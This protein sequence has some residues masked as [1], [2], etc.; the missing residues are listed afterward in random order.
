MRSNKLLYGVCVNN[1]D[2]CHNGKIPH[3]WYVIWSSV[4]MRVYSTKYHKKKPTYADYILHEDWKYSAN[5]K[6]WFDEQS[7]REGHHLDKDLLVHGNKI[8]GP[9]TCVFVPPALNNLF[10]DC[11][12][13]RRDTPLGVGHRGDGKRFVARVRLDSR[14]VHLGHYGTPEEAQRAYNRAKHAHCLDKAKGYLESGEIDQRIHDAVV[15]KAGILF[16]DQQNED[17]RIL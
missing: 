16:S 15:V 12:S 17:L 5:F 4:L 2:I 10:G 14:M 13:G 6:R 7:V 8:Y 3:R 11:W 1:V 9:D